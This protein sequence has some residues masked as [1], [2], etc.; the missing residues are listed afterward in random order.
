MGRLLRVRELGTLLI[1]LLEMAFFG[2]YLWPEGGRPHPFLNP[3]N[4]VLILKYSSIY[5]ISAIGAAMVIISG[6]ID[7][8]PG[9]VIA[10]SGGVTGQ[11]YVVS[12]RPLLPSTPAGL[13]AGVAAGG[14][15]SPPLGVGRLPP[16]IPRPRC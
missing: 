14:V 9:A 10:L 11:L 2:W 5:G 6:G 15:H 4:A 12:G 1:L 16:C 13:L 7:L 8:A 3:G